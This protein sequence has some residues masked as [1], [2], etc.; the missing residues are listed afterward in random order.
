MK[1]PLKNCLFI[2]VSDS[3]FDEAE[4]LHWLLER[5]FNS[6]QKALEAARLARTARQ[7][8]WLNPLLRYDGFA[9]L[10]SGVARLLD[11]VDSFHACHSLESL[12]GLSDA[13]GQSDMRDHYRRLRTPNPATHPSTP[14]KTF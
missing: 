1:R 9:P 5:N 11:H 6:Y 13:L 10:A 14:E 12:E 8:I 7:L 3:S 4:F 2:C